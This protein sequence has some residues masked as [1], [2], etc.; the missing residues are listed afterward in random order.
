MLIINYE[1]YGE[2][3]LVYPFIN[4]VRRTFILDLNSE[5]TVLNKK[6]YSYLDPEGNN[7]L[8][9]I[10]LSFF[11]LRMDHQLL[12]LRNLS[13]YELDGTT[14]HGVFG[15]DFFSDY[16]INSIIYNNNSFILKPNIK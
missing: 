13:K 12:K 5:Q 11:H 15:Q 8:N 14:I 4:M 2:L 10:R 1:T 16:D 9:F 3:K 7:K 6:Y